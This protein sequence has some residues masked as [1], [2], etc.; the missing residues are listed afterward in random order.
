MTSTQIQGKGVPGESVHCRSQMKDD[1]AP[2]D[3][4]VA[5]LA[6]SSAFVRLGRP[7]VPCASGGSGSWA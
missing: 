7:R 3:E 5:P 2:T 1:K 4:H 6:T